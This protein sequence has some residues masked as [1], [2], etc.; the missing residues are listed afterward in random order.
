MK[1]LGI[2]GELNRAHDASVAFVEN[3]NV[4]FAIEEERLSRVRH[5]YDSYPLLSIQRCF[6]DYSISENDIDFIAVGWDYPELYR[7]HELAWNHLEFAQHI[8]VNPEK[9][10]YVPHH[11]SHAASTYFTSG[12][13]NALTFV[14]DGQGESLSTSVFLGRDGKL[15]PIYSS[16][17]SF[18]YFFG[19]LTRFCGFKHG[20]EGKLMG[21]ASYGNICKNM[22]NVLSKEIFFDKAKGELCSRVLPEITL[23]ANDE[24]EYS[25]R[26]WM[27]IFE[28][29]LPRH[30]EKICELDDNAI[31]YCNLA[32]T[33]QALMK[34]VFI[35]LVL[36]YI[37]KVGVKN[38]CIA[39]GV[40][41]NCTMNGEL[42]N[43]IPEIENMFIQPAANDGG[44]SLGAA[45]YVAA[46]K[47][48]YTNYQMNAYL[49]TEYSDAEILSTLEN[50]NIKYTDP[51]DIS[52]RIAELLF[53]E[54]SVAI[55]NGRCEFGPRALG[56][57]SILMSARYAETMRKLNEQKGREIWRPLAPLMLE[58]NLKKYFL[59]KIK[60]SPFMTFTFR[61]TER[62][63]KDI[64]A[65]VHIDNTA[66]VQTI[67]EQQNKLLFD[68]LIEY[69]KFGGLAVI[70]TS[71]NKRGEPIVENPINALESFQKMGLDYL[72][73]GK[74]LVEKTTL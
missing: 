41:L 21:L 7:L 1:I 68:I 13:S 32:Q 8:G 49:G 19:A 45:L 3:G 6:K 37:Q 64:P 63:M 67:N 43:K 27:I 57:R 16:P 33:A 44:V 18:G 24:E 31:P 4:I 30:Y 34:D 69:E 50:K 65:A 47:G 40:G 59:S 60:S 22:Y 52:K 26:K 74:Y 56:N 36:Y 46:M 71:F 23:N 61:A 73:I 17:V 55:F 14:I 39:G 12:F 70:N 38:I 35:D 72:L 58:S 42:C 51:R 10:I 54:K 53:E 9:I 28:K 5:A 25:F 48:C 29:V 2:L 15:T 11:I 20:E 62:A 66:R